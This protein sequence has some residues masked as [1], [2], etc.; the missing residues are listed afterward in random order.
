MQDVIVDDDTAPTWSS[1]LL[2]HKSTDKPED[3]EE[4]GTMSRAWKVSL[5]VSEADLGT[6][7][8]DI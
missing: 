5:T 3:F 6:K 4:D 1:D 2:Y 7:V 8:G